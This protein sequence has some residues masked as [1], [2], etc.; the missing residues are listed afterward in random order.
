MNLPVFTELRAAI[1]ALLGR[2]V[3]RAMELAA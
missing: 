1:W 3:T 2:E